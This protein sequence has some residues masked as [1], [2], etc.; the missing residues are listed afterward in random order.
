MGCS[1]VRFHL[2]G[3]VGIVRRG[4]CKAGGGE[5]GVATEGDVDERE[6]RRGQVELARTTGVLCHVTL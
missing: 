3:D 5:F 2:L 1:F 4:V 6:E